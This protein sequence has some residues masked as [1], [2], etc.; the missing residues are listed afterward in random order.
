MKRIL[1]ILNV[2]NID[3]LDTAISR[4]KYI[5]YTKISI[6]PYIIE[7]LMGNQRYTLS[8]KLYTAGDIVNEAYRTRI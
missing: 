7:T 6:Y 2:Y 8:Y 1:S 5:L 3:D 4:S